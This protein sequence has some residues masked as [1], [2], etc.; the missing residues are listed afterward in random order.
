MAAPV[1]PPTK[2]RRSKKAAKSAETVADS[3]EEEEEEERPKKK[4]KKT[5]EE[6]RVEEPPKQ[7]EGSGSG[8]KGKGKEKEVPQEESGPK[9]GGETG[10]EVPQ[11]PKKPQR[12][13]GK[14]RELELELR[15]LDLKE[16]MVRTVVETVRLRE[17]IG[18]LQKG[19]REWLE[20][21]GKGD[22]FSAYVASLQA[23]GRL[24]DDGEEEESGEGPEGGEEQG[25]E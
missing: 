19:F 14:W 2:R 5:A 23:L 7:A 13:F 15:G 12:Y 22:A 10:G 6:P 24:E 11:R 20:E 18:P 17:E 16:L 4:P 9:E 1:T 8:D 25:A 3:D 21:K